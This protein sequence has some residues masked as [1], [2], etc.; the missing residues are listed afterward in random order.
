MAQA[1]PPVDSQESAITARC[2][3]SRSLPLTLHR[4]LEPGGAVGSTPRSRAPSNP[5]R[6]APY[7]WSGKHP[8]WRGRRRHQ[9]PQGSL[10]GP[11]Q[12]FPGLRAALLRSSATA[13]RPFCGI[14]RTRHR[15]GCAPASGFSPPRPEPCRGRQSV[16]VARSFVA[17]VF[18]ALAPVAAPDHR[19]SLDRDVH[20]S[21][22]VGVKGD[23]AYV[24]GVRSGREAPLWSRWQLPKPLQLTPG[25]PAVL[26]AEE[27]RGL[28]A[29]IA[30]AVTLHSL[31]R[32]HRNRHDVRVGDA[33]L[34]GG[35]HPVTDGITN[36]APGSPRILAPP[37]PAAERAAVD[38]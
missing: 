3:A 7:Q 2:V 28:G 22:G 15:M 17:P 35:S 12:G 23:P 25:L 11:A 13:R 18:P 26:R 5:P 31:C 16:G 27:R 8:Y 34:E 14:R 6:R 29:S 32:T 38:Y 30:D 33:A 4:S 9:A 36:G 21:L 19:A 10:S 37:Q 1:S 24:A 20:P